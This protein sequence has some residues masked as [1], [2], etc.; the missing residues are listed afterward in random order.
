MLRII[1]AFIFLSCRNLCP[2]KQTW[3]TFRF[4]ELKCHQHKSQYIAKLFILYPSSTYVRFYLINFGSRRKN[5]S[6]F[7]GWF[8]TNRRVISK[9][10][11]C[12]SSFLACFVNCFFLSLAGSP[13]MGDIQLSMFDRRGIIEVEVIRARG[14]LRKP[15][16]KTL[17]GFPI[18]QSFCSY[19]LRILTVA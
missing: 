15:G 18:F 4:R 6:S 14:L 13:H 7:F 1:S 19:S 16:S 5:T 11:D 2:W 3:T 9:E 12:S 10:T 8:L 17:P